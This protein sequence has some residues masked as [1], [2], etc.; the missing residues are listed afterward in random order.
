MVHAKGTTPQGH[1]ELLTVPPYVEWAALARANARVAAALDVRIAGVPARELRA[2]ARETAL[3][4]AAEF[5]R[6]LGVE[7]TSGAG[8]GAPLVM[9]GHQPQLYHPGVWAKVFLLQ[10]LAQEIGGTGIDLVVD[11]DGFDAVE[12]TAPCLRPEIERCRQY[13]A[14]GGTDACYACS[15]VPSL[16]DIETF[17][18]AGEQML[19]TLPAPAL[20]RHF[21]AF[22]DALASANTD[23]RNLAELVT[24]ARRRYE[25]SAGT[26]YLE[27]PVTEEAVTAPFRRFA[28]SL[29]GEAERFALAYNE[30]LA[31][32][33]AANRVRSVVQP[34]PDLTFDGDLVETPFW[35]VGER[36]RTAVW[37]RQGD[38]TEL[39]AG[40]EV[41]CRLPADPDAAVTALEESG[42][43]LAPKAVVLTAYQRLLVADLFIH[44]VG[45]GRYDRVTDDVV[46]RF[47]GVDL[48]PFVVASLT[49]QLPLGASVVGDREVEE[50]E[51]RVQTAE[52][53][54]DRL[55][56]E[57]EFD[58]EAERE[59]AEA[60]AEEKARL[61]AAIEQPGADR[62]ALGAAIRDANAGLADVLAPL[63]AE[64]RSRA[65]DLRA[66]R[67]AADILTDRTYPFCLWS[68]Q[69]I[70]DKVG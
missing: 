58:D 35:L 9:T 17:R 25:A 22:C 11:S 23:A 41:V 10:R 61:V 44:G 24:F 64:A 46:R 59:R 66:R 6:Y 27:L 56:D 69:E 32:Y 55:L 4:A 50:A 26:T 15:P 29:L 49:V 47:F 52:H 30:A 48:P 33:R 14:I 65:E 70:Q 60:L 43:L 28:V 12:L 62:K 37:A 20:P 57:V 39:L 51:R 5:S 40:G 53:N 19:S 1:G 45:G 18:V 21:G 8:A 7:V 16:A 68:P 34:F 3:A 2:E 42:V 54:P 67:D 63:V 36:G 13:L 31:A 38:V